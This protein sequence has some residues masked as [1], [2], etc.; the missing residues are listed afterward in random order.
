MS[1][2]RFG[3]SMPTELS[4]KFDLLIKK[5]KYSNRSEAIRDLI[6][7]FLIEDEILNDSEVIGVV[8]ILYNHHQRE[9]SEKLTAVQHE[10]HHLVLSAMHIHLDHDNCVEVII[11]QG[12]SQKVKN[13]AET[14]IA[15][16]GVK[17]GSLN[18]TSSGKNLQ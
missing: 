5:K 8:S 11:M 13:L 1:L 15:T 2:L 14:L 7:R 16:K 10:Y 9:L 12:Q 3:I 17:H 6:R 4:T 18:L